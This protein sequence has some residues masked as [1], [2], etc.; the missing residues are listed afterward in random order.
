[1]SQAL[2]DLRNFLTG[3][4]RQVKCRGDPPSWDSY[5]SRLHRALTPELLADSLL[6]SG[7]I[8]NKLV[9]CLALEKEKK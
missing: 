6:T 3:V 8:T 4:A 2:F 1:M 7:I 9:I 5:P